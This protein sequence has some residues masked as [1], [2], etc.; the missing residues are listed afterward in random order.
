MREWVEM[1]KLKFELVSPDQLLLSEDV[2]MVILPGSEGYLGA[3]PNHAPLATSLH[4]G[5]VAIYNNH[6]ITHRFYIDGGFANISEKGCTILADSAT[7]LTDLNLE[8]LQSKLNSIIADGD[9]E[10]IARL[11][12]MIHTMNNADIIAPH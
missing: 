3:L 4:A 6:N 5:L 1:S 2:E 10:E 8:Q 11:Q 9:E 12:S 7:S